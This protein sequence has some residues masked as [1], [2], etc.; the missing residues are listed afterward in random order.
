MDSM[1]DEMERGNY[2]QDLGLALDLR[3]GSDWRSIGVDWS[4]TDGD[5]DGM[6]LENGVR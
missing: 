6:A 1:Q 4:D 5:G 3:L 2:S